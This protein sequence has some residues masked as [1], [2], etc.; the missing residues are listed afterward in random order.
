MRNNSAAMRET[1]PS[2]QFLDVNGTQVHAHIEGTGP[3]L[4]LIHGAGGNLRDYTFSMVDKLKGDFRVI[5]FDRPGHGYT[6]RIAQRAELGETPAEQA[7]LLSAAAKQLNVDNAIIAG[8]SFGGAV[9]LAWVLNHPEQISGLVMFAGVSNEWEGELD[10]WY[11]T[12]TGF[13][14]RNILVPTL[15]ALASRKRLEGTTTGIFEPDPV[16]Q[17]Y[18]DHMGPA[19][20]KSTVT[21]QSTTQQVGF[22]KPHIVEM[23]KRYKD[24]KIPVEIVH[25]TADTT[26]PINVHARV[27]A[28][29]VKG[30]NLTALPGVGHMPHHAAEPQAISAIKRA[31]NRA[32]LR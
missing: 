12:T 17:G 1:P 6:Q 25:G 18:L 3:D 10:S 13:F 14:G 28:S 9:A 30:A 16:P 7:A 5:A 19:L 27:L 4:I 21:L 23:Q 11:T 32:G 22:V 31:A 8:H 20:S 26:V 29:Q 24:I 15:S 2:G